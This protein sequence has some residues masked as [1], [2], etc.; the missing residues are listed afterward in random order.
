[1]AKENGQIDDLNEPVP[2]IVVIVKI[3]G[4]D[5][6][7]L[8]SE[9]EFYFWDRYKAEIS[10]NKIRQLWEKRFNRK[11]N[12]PKEEVEEYMNEIET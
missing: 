7:Y 5:M 6:L 11:I 9:R 4:D 10:A 8:L 1:M 2:S 12:I 3:D